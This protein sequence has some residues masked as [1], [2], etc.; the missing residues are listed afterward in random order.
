MPLPLKEEGAY[1]VVCRGD[2]DY[3]SGLVLVSPLELAV[4]EDVAS[5]RVRVTAKDAV[6]DR[7]VSKV[8]VKVIG[9]GNSDFVT[10]ETDLRGIF[11]ADA[12]RG[13]TTVIAAARPAATRFSAGRRSWA[14][15]QP[16]PE[17]AR[18]RTCRNKR[19]QRAEFAARECGT[20]QERRSTAAARQLPQFVANQ[21]SR[22]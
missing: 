22:E 18:P 8:L 14:T 17:R 3:A 19:R 7:Y 5:G 10:G 1:L 6:A 20:Q 13:E 16:R 11:K 12:I 15:Q 21:E 4:Q 2:D 9:S